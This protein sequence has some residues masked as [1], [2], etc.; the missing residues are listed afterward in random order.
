MAAAISQEGTPAV[1]DDV[2]P[3]GPKSTTKPELS[4]VKELAESTLEGPAGLPPTTFDSTGLA[5]WNQARAEGAT[6]P[7]PV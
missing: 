7:P 4:N 5:A 3:P 2:A 1:F 6:E